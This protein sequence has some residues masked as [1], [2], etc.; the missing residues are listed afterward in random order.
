MNDN[1]NDNVV[2]FVMSADTIYSVSVHNCMTSKKK[3]Y[4]AKF[5]YALNYCFDK[6][7]D[8]NKKCIYWIN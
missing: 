4:I 5:L 3:N 7:K 1:V 2:S 8:L 6:Y